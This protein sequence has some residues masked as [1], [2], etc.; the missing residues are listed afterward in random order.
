MLVWAVPAPRTFG[1][2]PLVPWQFYSSLS[3]PSR[4]YVLRRPRG[5]HQCPAPLACPQLS[6]GDGTCKSSVSLVLVS[7]ASSE[8][9]HP[10]LGFR[11]Y[12][13]TSWPSH[14]LLVLQRVAGDSA[15][16]WLA[17]T[18]R[19]LPRPSRCELTCAELSVSQA[20]RRR[21]GQRDLIGGGWALIGQVPEV[22]VRFGVR[23]RGR[24]PGE[25]AGDFAEFHTL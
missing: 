20:W 17:L 5:L 3:F 6:G 16:A 24:G 14:G 13:P 2:K 9:G 7:L 19:E 22:R 4:L 23:W 8:F 25:G 15:A 11:G 12:S 21:A 10:P 18:P 1:L